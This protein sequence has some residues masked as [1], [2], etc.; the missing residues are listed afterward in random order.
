MAN[1][2]KSNYFWTF[3]DEKIFRN[4]VSFKVGPLDTVVFKIRSTGLEIVFIPKD[5]IQSAI[6][7]FQY[8][9]SN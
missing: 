7:M 6:C 3:D 1:E 8:L 4:Q 9:S 5:G 2:M